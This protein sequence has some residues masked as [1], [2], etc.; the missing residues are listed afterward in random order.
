MSEGVNVG[1]VE[2]LDEIAPLTLQGTL[3]PQKHAS[4]HSSTLRTVPVDENKY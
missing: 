4:V 2:T 3:V 1:A